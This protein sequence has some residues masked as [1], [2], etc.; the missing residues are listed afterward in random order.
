MMPFA[1]SDWNVS[2]ELEENGWIFRVAFEEV[3]VHAGV[4]GLQQDASVGWVVFGAKKKIIFFVMMAE[5]RV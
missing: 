4:D 3:D 2:W 1:V 5:S